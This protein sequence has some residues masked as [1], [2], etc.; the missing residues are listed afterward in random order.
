M[1][2]ISLLVIAAMS[3]LGGTAGAVTATYLTL[4]QVRAWFQ[5]RRA[6]LFDRNAVATTIVDILAS[7]QYRTVQG[8]FNTRS[9]TWTDYRVLEG[10]LSPELATMH[11]NRRVVH[12]VI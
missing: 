6:A 1:E 5:V 8:I 10:R 7:G 2:P 12:H 4:P 9:R 3:L 11:R